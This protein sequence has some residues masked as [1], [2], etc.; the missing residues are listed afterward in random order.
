MK[1]QDSPYGV[2]PRE[3]SIRPMWRTIGRRYASAMKRKYGL[4]IVLAGASLLSTACMGYDVNGLA[5]PPPPGEGTQTSRLPML[6]QQLQGGAAGVELFDATPSSQVLAAQDE[7]GKALVNVTVTATATGTSSSIQ[8]GAKT[9]TA[10]PARSSSV[11]T[12]QPPPT[13]TPTL[14]PR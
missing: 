8:V 6:V 11:N 7:N 1:D 5:T 4:V 3:M 10:T 12:P 14:Q 2:A 13:R 9:P